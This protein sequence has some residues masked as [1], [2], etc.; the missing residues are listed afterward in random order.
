MAKQK[1]EVP[2][3]EVVN[4]IT[5]PKV[6][7]K[8]AYSLL[9]KDGEFHLVRISYNKDLEVGSA[10]IIKSGEDQFDMEYEFETATEHMIYD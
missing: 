8:N 4:Q 5:P 3:T 1:T 10:M 2:E 7:D 9:E 6:F